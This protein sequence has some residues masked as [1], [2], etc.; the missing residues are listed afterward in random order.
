MIQRIFFKKA[1]LVAFRPRGNVSFV[2]SPN[3]WIEDCH[4]SVPWCRNTTYRS[5]TF[6]DR[7]FEAV[8]IGLLVVSLLV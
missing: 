4:K 3:I 1:N 6:I 8:V 5:M 7:F 2:K